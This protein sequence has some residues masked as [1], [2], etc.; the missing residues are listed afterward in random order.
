MSNW[1]PWAGQ[2]E[3]INDQ[4]REATGYSDYGGSIF[5]KYNCLNAVENAP[6]VFESMP[7]IYSGEYLILAPDFYCAPKEEREWAKEFIEW[8]FDENRYPIYDEHGYSDW[9]WQE[10]DKMMQGWDGENFMSELKRELE[11][12]TDWDGTLI[13]E[14]G[15][16]EFWD[17]YAKVTEYE[18][19]YFESASTIVLPEYDPEEIVAGLLAEYAAT[20][21]PTQNDTLFH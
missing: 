14:V 12:I 6:G 4:L 7:T 9:E 5:D 18:M 21:V 19:P 1:K 16:Q 13:P 8:A 2:T 15:S 20:F 17:L 11:T 10:M 3:Q